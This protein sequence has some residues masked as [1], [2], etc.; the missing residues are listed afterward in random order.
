M[1]FELK[2]QFNVDK[3]WYNCQAIAKTCNQK[4]KHAVLDNFDCPNMFLLSLYRLS[5]V[6]WRSLAGW[7]TYKYPLRER[8]EKNSIVN[9]IS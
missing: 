6:H 2:M 8:C 9:A 7:F 5:L 3:K 4:L 1:S